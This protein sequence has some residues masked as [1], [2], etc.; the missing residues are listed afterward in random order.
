MGL[1]TPEEEAGLPP[2][3]KFVPVLECP[4][5]AKTHPEGLARIGNRKT[6]CKRCNRFSQAV[7]RRVAKDLM[8][9][10]R[11]EAKLLREIAED[12][13]Y[14]EIVGTTEGRRGTT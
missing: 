6:T 10:H 14:P 11:E 1:P 13:L 7:R 2:G 12:I 4:D 3:V 8:D 9:L 5:C